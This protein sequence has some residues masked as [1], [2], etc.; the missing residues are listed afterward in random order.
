MAGSRGL[1]VSLLLLLLL[2][3]APALLPPAAAAVA[4][5][6]TAAVAL[7]LSVVPLR[8]P[9]D[10]NSY[11]VLVLGFSD[12]S[13]NPSFALNATTV[14]LTSSQEDVGTVPASVVIPAG[15]DYIVVNFTTTK[16]EGSTTITASSPGYASVSTA[17]VTRTPSGFA[18]QL[19][20]VAEP[21][22][23]LAGTTGA[24][25]VQLLDLTGAPAVASE[26]V[27]VSIVSS[28][29]ST[30][31]PASGSITIPKGASFS[32]VNFTSGYSLGNALVTASASSFTSATTTISIIGASAY[33]LHVSAQPS[34]IAERTNGRIVVW[35]TDQLGHPAIASSAVSVSITSSNLAVA[36]FS[37]TVVTIGAGFTS[38]V[39]NF[40]A[41][42]VQGSSTV[43]VAAQN[44]QAGFDTISTFKPSQT[45]TAIKLYVGPN[46]V[47]ANAATYPAITVALVNSTGYP[48]LAA[49]NTI[50]NIT[51]GT[52]GVGTTSSYV[53][54]PSGSE[55][56]VAS[57]ST[58]Y[59]VGITTVTAVAQNLASAQVQVSSYGPVPVNLLVS[60]VS[61]TV[62]ANGATDDVLAVSLQDAA[63]NP[64]IAPT[65]ISVHLTSS[66]P[67][68]AQ[69]SPYVTIRAG[70]SYIL[71]SVQV[72]ISAGNTNIT[73]SSTNYGSSSTILDAQI[74][75]PTELHLYVGPSVAINSTKGQES[76]VSVQLQDVNGLPASAS[77]PTTVTVTSSNT[78]VL[79]QPVVLSIAPGHDY[80]SAFVSTLGPG[81]TNLTA[82][83]PG[84]GASSAVLN[85]LSAPITLALA[86]SP[87]IPFT[88]ES[89]TVILTAT[90]LGAGISGA[91]VQ[92]ST[93]FGVL[94]STNS[95]TNAAGQAVVVLA[96]GSPGP[97]TLTAT[98]RSP[99]LGVVNKTV[100]VVFQPT[101]AKPAKTL[102]QELGIYIYVIIVAVVAVVVVVAFLFI[103]RMRKNRAAKG[104]PAEAESF[105][106]LE[107][108]PDVGDVGEDNLA[109]GGR[110]RDNYIGE[111]F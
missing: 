60:S 50:V 18:T 33:A 11:A 89:S 76:M 27:T 101:P 104:G 67:T 107:E 68:T 93:S 95:T 34:Q 56:A 36:Q 73:A 58:T 19:R 99:L 46:P 3:A 7:S 48:A 82:S 31:N 61:S 70:Q 94:S 12:A 100:Q 25:I 88:N 21:T 57:F 6:P 59:F 38:A 54:I 17:V 26:P 40:T 103:R 98:V 53:N 83:A 2:G 110:T 77:S 111:G 14:Y 41:G 47:V 62:L 23:V 5:T 66:Q 102:L 37:R 87:Q 84:L 4:P 64:A 78:A 28:S 42:S 8:L 10:G 86:P 9:A 52:T 30:I 22:N 49:S 32:F 16:Q 92:W 108:Q 69:V 35:L 51:S 90:A 55:S 45:P 105:D 75:A 13:R 85:V 79:A 15:A 91:N 72:G 43:T 1:A 106:D 29:Q 24:L 44:L 20:L 96:S 109:Y 71:T 74:P 97:A 65:P 80:A 63:G 39:A 81:D